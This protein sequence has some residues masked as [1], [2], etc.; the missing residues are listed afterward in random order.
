MVYSNFGKS[1]QKIIL[2]REKS[3]DPKTLEKVKCVLQG[4]KFDFLFIDGDH[5]YEGVK[6]DFEAYSPLV[7]KDGIIAFH[8]RVPHDKVHDPYGVVGV[9]R[10]W[11]EI[12]HSYKYLEIVSNGNQGWAGIGVPYV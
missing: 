7:G 11:N 8:D 9:S 3:H 2:I 1:E 4:S 12:K 6:R 5:S 10:F